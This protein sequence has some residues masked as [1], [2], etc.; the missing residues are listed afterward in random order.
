MNIEIMNNT[1]E[2]KI[3]VSKGHRAAASFIGEFL[4]THL[5]NNMDESNR[6]MNEK[7]WT[8]KD[9]QNEFRTFLAENKIKMSI[10]K[11][12][13]SIKKPP[14]SYIL[15]QNEYRPKLL[16]DEKFQ[17]YLTQLEEEGIWSSDPDKR[18]K[19][20]SGMKFKTV[21]EHVVTEWNK[22][23]ND[24]IMFAKYKAE[25]EKYV[26]DFEQKMIQS[27]PEYFT[28]NV[29]K[30]RIPKGINKPRM[31][32]FYFNQDER[33]I[34]EQEFPEWGKKD[35]NLELKKRWR[36]LQRDDTERIKTYCDIRAQHLK[37]YDDFLE[38]E[39][40]NKE[41]ITIKFE[42]HCAEDVTTTN[43]V[44]PSVMKLLSKTISKPILKATSKVLET[45]G[46]TGTKK[47]KIESNGQPR[48]KKVAIATN[49][50]E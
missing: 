27:N 10:E 7:I 24:E 14:S 43:N 48:K 13:K 28:Q 31:P 32:E 11:D 25:H 18:N 17:Q 41:E 5:F 45:N 35:V 49:D 50:E 37:E 34:V 42:D 19:E 40:Q 23:K 1:K 15:F 12:G 29:K 6:L 2:K 30:P 9:L 39:N 33:K 20:L 26:K 3:T 47:R 22:I 44:Q 21:N 16:A 36:I 38:Q 46:E 8:S 4:K